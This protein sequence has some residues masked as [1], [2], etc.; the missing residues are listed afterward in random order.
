MVQLAGKVAIVTGA[1]RGIGR[2]I[3]EEMASCGAAVGLFVRQAASAVDVSNAIKSAGGRSRVFVVDVRQAA[4]VNDAVR[5]TLDWAGRV[6]CLINN[7]GV[8]APIARI[9]DTADASWNDSIAA[10]LV[11]PMNLCRA[12]LPALLESKGVILNLSSSAATLAKEGWSAYCCGKAGLAM[13][14]K[15]L[16]AEHADD[17][18]KAFNFRPGV[19]DTD[20]Q[21]EIRASGI[22]EV[23]RLDRSKLAPTRDPAHAVAWICAN[24]FRLINGDEISLGDEKFRGLVFGK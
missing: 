4:G 22:N 11:G 9:V 21:S 18:L 20:M 5:S 19:V 3:A 12:A 1:N 24:P 8:I 7:A 15:C 17:G 2:A 14:T 13:L 23:S 16:L 10:N 6:D